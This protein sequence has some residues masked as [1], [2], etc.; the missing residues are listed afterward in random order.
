MQPLLDRVLDIALSPALWLCVVLGLV[1]GLLFTLWRGGGF[2]QLWRDLLA[3]VL[4]FGFGQLLASFLRLPTLAVGEVHLLWGSLFAVV[5]LLARRRFWPPRT[6]S[7]PA[8]PA[9]AP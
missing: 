2:R 5:A 3:G 6:K 7:K 9:P 1:Y 8:S 4:G